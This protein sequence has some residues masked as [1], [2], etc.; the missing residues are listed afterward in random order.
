MGEGTMDVPCRGCKFR[1]VACH[2]KCE[3]Y[4]DYRKRL[5]MGGNNQCK[6]NVIGAIDYIHQQT[7]THGAQIVWKGNL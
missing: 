4:L 3:S 5:M 7:I 1:E 2:G 6:E